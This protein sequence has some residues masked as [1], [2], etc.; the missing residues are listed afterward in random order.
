MKNKSVYT[1]EGLACICVIF[2]HCKF[3]NE[4]GR[5][6]DFFSRFA[7]PVFFII[8]GY[9]TYS[10]NIEKLKN[11]SMKLLK[12]LILCIFIY[13]IILHIQEFLINEHY[14]FFEINKKIFNIKN[15]I[16]FIVLN[17]TSA[18]IPHLWFIA[19]LIYCYIFR[20]MTMNKKLEKTYKYIPFLLVINYIIAILSNIIT[21][22][23]STNAIIRN[24]LMMGLPFYIIGFYIRKNKDKY[25][26]IKNIKLIIIA[27]LGLGIIMIERIMINQLKYELFLDL[28]IGNIVFTISIFILAINNPNLFNCKFLSKIGEKY[29]LYIYL[30]HYAIIRI[31]NVIEIK[32]KISINEYAKPII[33]FII[34]YVISILI[35]RFKNN[36]FKM[37]IYK[38]L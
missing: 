22:G 38:N 15:L 3:P 31:I 9:F 4:L 35:A 13:F 29:S 2:I 11:K 25:I 34:A 8:S 18:I 33:V 37:K 30:I 14:N 6:I 21:N 1:L 26:N 10:A 5:I 20:I 28:Y 12:M 19:A 27:I 32:G 7:V 36:K 17:R 16:T 23:E 24:W